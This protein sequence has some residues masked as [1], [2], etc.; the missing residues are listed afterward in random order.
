[1]IIVEKKDRKHINIVTNKADVIINEKYVFDKLC[2]P[3][4]VIRWQ[5]LELFLSFAN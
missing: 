4:T 5:L 1:M 3:G 2:W